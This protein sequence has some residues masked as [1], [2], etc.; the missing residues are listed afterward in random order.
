MTDK[1]RI[2]GRLALLGVLSFVSAMESVG[3]EARQRADIG[4]AVEA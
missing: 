1:G 2:L 4:E 3:R